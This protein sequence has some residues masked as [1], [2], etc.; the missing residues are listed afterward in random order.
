[1][2]SKRSR[3]TGASL[4]LGELRCR[5]VLHLARTLPEGSSVD[6][7]ECVA[8]ARGMRAG[9][10]RHGRDT[11]MALGLLVDDP[12]AGLIVTPTRRRT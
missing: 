4:W 7:L 10:F 5:D 12:R 9:A 11:A 2:V 8:L 6:D 3:G 1:M